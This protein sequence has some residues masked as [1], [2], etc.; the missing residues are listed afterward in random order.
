MEGGL[1]SVIGIMSVCL[2]EAV[3]QSLPPHIYFLEGQWESEELLEP[4]T[5]PCAML[6]LPVCTYNIRF[7]LLVL[8]C[9]PVGWEYYL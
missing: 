7:L 4:V 1:A 3:Q 2:E 5:H 9:F 6:G 8:F